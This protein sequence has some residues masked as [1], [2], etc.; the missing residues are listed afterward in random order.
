MLAALWASGVIAVGYGDGGLP[1][2][3]DRPLWVLPVLAIGLWIGYLV[4]PILVNRLTAS[5]P[6]VDFDLRAGPVQVVGAALVG[7]GSQLLLLPALYWV[8]SRFVDGDPG[9]TAQAIVERVDGGV[10][11]LLLVLAVVVM[12]PLAEEFFYRGMLLSAI[13][14]RFGVG[15][16]VVASSAVFAVAHQEPILF[17]GLFLFAAVLAWLTIS[18]GRIGVAIVGH[19]AFNAT[20]VIQLLA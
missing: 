11:V 16:G 1:P 4:G 6:L 12:A 8:L 19:M 2:V 14:R 20:T 18:T 10:D 7:V 17:P 3:E 13:G 15:A 5:G 9:A